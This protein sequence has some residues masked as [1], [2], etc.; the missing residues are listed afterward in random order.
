M[1]ILFDHQT[2]SLQKY[3]GISRYFANLIKGINKSGK[4]YGYIMS[5]FSE[6]EYIKN[7]HMA[8]SNSVGQKLFN[9]KPK[10]LYNWNRRFSRW[11]LRLRKFDVFHPTYYDPYFIKYLKKP[12]VITVHDMLHELYP[13]YFAD[14]QE[15]TARKRKVMERADLLIAISE[16]T[17]QDMI[18]VY[19]QMK[20]KIRVVYHGYLGL[21]SQPEPDHTLPAKYILFVGE[22]WHYKNFPF[23]VQGISRL[24]TSSPELKLVCAGGKA[25][26]ADETALLEQYNIAGKCLQMDVTDV[27]L[28]Q[29]YSQAEL[30]V[31][32]SLHEGFGLPLLEAFANEC[33]VICCDSSC[34]PEI[35]GNAALY[36]DPL[37][38]DHL[39]QMVSRVLQDEEL[40]LELKKKGL[41]RLELFTFDT[42]VQNTLQVYQSLIKV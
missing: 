18:K 28:Q 3:G 33:P 15:V 14:A 21:T 4:G 9:N 35:A 41:K 13:H 38:P 40:R 32:P 1:K 25:F 8:L 17:R 7:E 24:L 37:Q 10:R 20:D 27:I 42:C 16:Y 34:M 11:S 31:F 26:T 19:P 30:F 2:F 6:N 39:F 22:R 12:C 29:L 5:L 23:F 36:F